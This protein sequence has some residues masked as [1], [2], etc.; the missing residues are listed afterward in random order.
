MRKKELELINNIP[1]I[2][3][4]PYINKGINCLSEQLI[5][6]QKEDLYLTFR[7]IAQK[8]KNE[9]NHNKKL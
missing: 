4:Y 3:K 6:T 2:D 7:D 8:V 9:I 5:K 1:N